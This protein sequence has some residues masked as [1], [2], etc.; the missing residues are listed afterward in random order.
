MLA[1]RFNLDAQ[2][3]T[4][5]LEQTPRRETLAPTDAGTA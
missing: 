1:V 5:A 3:V 2:P 4:R